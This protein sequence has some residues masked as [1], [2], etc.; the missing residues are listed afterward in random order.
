MA[1]QILPNNAA[2][3]HGEA[4]QHIKGM[5]SPP[6]GPGVP[7]GMK[8]PLRE[9]ACHSLPWVCSH[10]E[11]IPPFGPSSLWQWPYSR[12]VALTTHHHTGYGA[13]CG[14]PTSTASCSTAW[15]C[16]C[17]APVQVRM[18]ELCPKHRIIKVGKELEDEVQ[19]S[20]RIPQCHMSMV[21]ELFHGQ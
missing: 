16:S 18:R 21:L 9:D 4:S 19:P 3:R 1:A 2:E 17:T 11:S 14:A 5:T 13:H 6:Q 8:H 7:V 15:G 20:A 12:C 10:F